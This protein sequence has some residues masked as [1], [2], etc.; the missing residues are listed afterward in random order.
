[1]NNKKLGRP[2]TGRDRLIQLIATIR[3]D[4]VE[5]LHARAAVGDR[6]T[7]HVLREIIDQAMKGDSRP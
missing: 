7:S 3:P 4:Q 1:M 5:W 2:R 6:S